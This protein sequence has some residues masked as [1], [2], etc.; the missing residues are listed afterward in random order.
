MRIRGRSLHGGSLLINLYT[1]LQTPNRFHP[2]VIRAV[3]IGLHGPDMRMA[4]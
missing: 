1:K 4:H 2:P 3:E